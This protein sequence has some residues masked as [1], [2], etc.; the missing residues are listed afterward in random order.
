MTHIK[1][2]TSL[3]LVALALFGLLLNSVSAGLPAGGHIGT[4]AQQHVNA[5][6][7]H[8]DTPAQ[9]HVNTKGEHIGTPAQEHVNTKG[10]HIGTSAKQHVAPAS[11]H[12]NAPSS[13]SSSSSP[14]RFSPHMA[15]VS[16]PRI[17]S[18]PPAS[19]DLQSRGR[20][21]VK[22]RQS[23]T[24]GKVTFYYGS[25]LLNPA[26]AG[27]PTPDDW[28]MTAAISFDSPFS[29]GDRVRISDGQG[30][31]VIVTVVDRCTGC[32]REWIDV[33]KGVFKHFSSLDTG[34]L[35][36]LTFHKV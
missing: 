1:R 22:A 28:S 34:V 23:L 18:P 26:C 17:A 30:K 6:G 12:V 15:S 35:H 36:D 7:Q 3:L 11:H 24:N 32:T 13:S 29:C 2:F 21:H 8:I 20:H 33:T 31:H 25:Q 9:Q 4:P 10:E 5:K 16:K 27:A 19:N 14:Q